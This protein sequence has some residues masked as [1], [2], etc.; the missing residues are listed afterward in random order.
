M[1][2]S[3][4]LVHCFGI[5]HQL[6]QQRQPQQQNQVGLSQIIKYIAQQVSNANSG[7]NATHVYQVLVQLAKQIA[8]FS[9]CS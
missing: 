8:V 4:I 3:N 2:F 5:R 6:Q 9:L 1:K 7:T